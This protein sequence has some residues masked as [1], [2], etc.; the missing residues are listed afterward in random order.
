MKKLFCMADIHGYWDLAYDTLDKY[1]FDINNPDHI[2]VHCGDLMDRGPDNLKCLELANGFPDDRKILIWG[3]HEELLV[4]ACARTFFMGHDYHNGTVGTV[5]EIAEIPFED[6]Y[7]SD[8]TAQCAM[9]KAMEH[10]EWVK[11]RNSCVDYAVVGPYVFVHGWIPTY[12]ADGTLVTSFDRAD[13]T[14]VDGYWRK[15]RWL[16]GMEE[17]AKGNRFMDK[18][19]VCGHW[20]TSWGHAYLH[21]NGVEFQEAYYRDEQDPNRIE[22]FEPFIDE[23][24]I[25]LDAC[26]AYS[27]NMNCVVLEVEDEEWQSKMLGPTMNKLQINM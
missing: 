8:L 9:M 20:H 16:N 21:D 13:G 23:G 6:V 18:T 4:D 24:I 26:T 5:A 7:M 25:A 27:G 17:W 19:I 15:A 11:Y 10:P 14:W 22:H 3:N 12:F 2:F 1:D